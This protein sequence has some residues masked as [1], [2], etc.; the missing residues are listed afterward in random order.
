MIYNGKLFGMYECHF[1]YE[2][3]EDIYLVTDIEKYHGISMEE[4]LPK[5]PTVAKFMDTWKVTPK[6]LSAIFRELSIPQRNLLQYGINGEVMVH[7]NAVTRAIRCENGAIKRYTYNVYLKEAQYVGVALQRIADH[8]FAN[9][10][11]FKPVADIAMHTERRY[12]D[13]IH[14]LNLSGNALIDD[15]NGVIVFENRLTV[16]D[17]VELYEHPETADKVIEVRRTH[18]YY[19]GLVAIPYGEEDGMGHM[20]TDIAT[21]LTKDEEAFLTRRVCNEPY[22]CG[23]ERMVYT[24]EQQGHPNF[25]GSSNAEKVRKFFIK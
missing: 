13:S 10:P 8:I 20:Y 3:P 17:L 4:I 18:A 6:E 1:N 21:L 15:L 22:I 12:K 16:A 11:R 19:D 7:E 2:V 25:F 9:D 23:N 14:E 24:G 5:L